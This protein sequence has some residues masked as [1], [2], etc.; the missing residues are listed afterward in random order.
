M[1]MSALDQELILAA[2]RQLAERTDGENHTVAA[3]IRTADGRIFTGMNMYHFTG[4]PCA[5]IVTLGTVI[6]AT[7]SAP[8]AIVAV[9]DEGRGVLSPCGRC[10]QILMDYAPDIAII[11]STEEGPR[12]VSIPDLLPYAYRRS[13]S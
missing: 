10:R 6:S 2:E 13:S 4:G 12:A 8:V 9:G 3:A 11:V 5:E 1:T 7:D